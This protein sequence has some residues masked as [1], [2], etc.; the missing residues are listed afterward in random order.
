MKLADGGLRASDIGDIRNIKNMHTEALRLLQKRQHVG[1]PP[2]GYDILFRSPLGCQHLMKP[3]EITPRQ[4]IVKSH[5]RSMNFWDSLQAAAVDVTSPVRATIS[6]PLP[7][8][9]GMLQTHGA[10]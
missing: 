7:L 5:I 8:C 3:L 1:L 2:N 9:N 10:L 4:L 6:D